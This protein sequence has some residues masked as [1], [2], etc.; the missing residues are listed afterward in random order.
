MISLDIKQS[1]S[2]DTSALN[3]SPKDEKPTL[4]FASLL[5]AVGSAKKDTDIKS[6]Q[7]GVI[8][9][10]LDD[11]KD[12]PAKT[13]TKE[14]KK[15]DIL[16]LLKNEKK[17]STKND[18]ETLEVNPKI[19]TMISSD[20]LKTVMYKAKRYLKNQIINSDGFKKKE[21]DSLPKTLNGLVQVAKK[22]GIDISKI[23]LEKVQ[24]QPLESKKDSKMQLV[25]GDFL[26]AT[27]KSL[28]IENKES[29]KALKATKI[30]D[31]T[32]D[33]VIDVKVKTSNLTSNVKQKSLNVV[34]KANVVISN[35][36]R[37]DTTKEKRISK[38]VQKNLKE[39]PLFKAQVKIEITTQELV[40]SKAVIIKSKNTKEKTQNTLEL[41]LR[42]E[43]VSQS[44][45]KSGVL[46]ADFSVATAKVIAP[47]ARTESVKNLESLLKNANNESDKV[48]S[49]IDGLNIAKVDSFEVKLHEA[50]QM[51][52]YLSQDV[53]SAIQD[54]KSPF[55]RI[56]VQLNPKNLGEVDLTI[57]QRGKNLH[58]NL[59]SNNVA[60]N[61]LAMN[62]NDLKVQLSNNG[63]NNASLN[64]NNN[65]Q[66]SDSSFGSQT[67]QQQQ[68]QRD[69][70][71]SRYN[72]FT[73]E[74][75]KEELLSS[76]EIVVP[77]Y[78]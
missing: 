61:T 38:E 44:S 20:E 53:K 35:Q 75:S 43:K 6:L 50:K 19:T 69:E 26:D 21:I 68:Q 70:A 11:T 33:A 4:S 72:Y 59:S 32:S 27:K 71:Q 16:S 52:K 25:K 24:E 1:S 73:K 58:I 23:T 39:T 76:L 9:L 64:F 56:K 66:S 65:S 49:K 74:E 36:E 57:V 60:I 55:T 63:I 5:N 40:N 62:A 22:V 3:L 12:T 31:T 41:L 46:S 77:Y 48:N 7:N 34:N 29:S 37:S 13:S 17:I 45:D 18:E 30:T 10:A 54:Y 28:N 78:A 51:M 42:G 47:T 2:T 8:T 15:T 67:Q 14:S